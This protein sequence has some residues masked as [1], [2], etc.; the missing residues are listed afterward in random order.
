MTTSVGNLEIVQRTSAMARWTA[1][2]APNV[3]PYWP[4]FDAARLPV[5][6]LMVLFRDRSEIEAALAES[7][8]RADQDLKKY[9]VRAAYELRATD[10]TIGTVE[11]TNNALTTWIS[12]VTQGATDEV[13]AELQDIGVDV[14]LLSYGN[15]K[16]RVALVSERAWDERV[17]LLSPQPLTWA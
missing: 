7:M 2:A 13:P 1:G 5:G 15:H 16:G 6:R 12:L 14:V 3:P 8:D 11:A 10:A 4:L 9:V 17:I